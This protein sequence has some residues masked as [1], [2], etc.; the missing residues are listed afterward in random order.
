[1]VGVE[2]EHQGGVHHTFS[3][4]RAL[5]A[6]CGAFVHGALLNHSKQACKRALKQQILAP[7]T[8][9]QDRTW[10]AMIEAFFAGT[11]ATGEVA[12]VERCL[13]RREYRNG[14]APCIG[15][16]QG[17]KRTCQHH[18]RMHMRCKTT[19]QTHTRTHTHAHAHTPTHTH[20]HTHTHAHTHPQTQACSWRP[21]GPSGPRTT[22]VSTRSMPRSALQWSRRS[23]T[24]PRAVS[25]LVARLSA[26]R[27]KHALVCSSVKQSFRGQGA[28]GERGLAARPS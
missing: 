20:T 9:A 11:A 23:P 15:R 4:C 17:V 28:A 5:G 1:M 18:T 27:N 19:A 21:P 26:V 8:P 14:E 22:G 7:P 3:K 6:S 24:S 16:G 10:D 12:A 25:F 2:G 13:Q